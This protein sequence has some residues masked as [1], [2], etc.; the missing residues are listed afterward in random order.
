MARFFMKLSSHKF[1]VVEIIV[2]R[3]LSSLHLH[4]HSIYVRCG[5]MNR[6]IQ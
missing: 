4:L 5:D 1:Q 2:E 6:P 3:K